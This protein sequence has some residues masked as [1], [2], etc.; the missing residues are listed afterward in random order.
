MGIAG[1]WTGAG[2]GTVWDNAK[3]CWV[4]GLGVGTTGFIV[5]PGIIE[6]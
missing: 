1:A 5:A 3:D 4:T 6:P 2:R